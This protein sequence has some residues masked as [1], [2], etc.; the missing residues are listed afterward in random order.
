MDSS[1]RRI[2][3][4]GK[5]SLSVTLPMNFVK[6]LKWRLKQKVVVSL[7]GSSIVIKDWKAKKTRNK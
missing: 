2:R 4:T 3:K 5:Y 7:R 1:I 6:E